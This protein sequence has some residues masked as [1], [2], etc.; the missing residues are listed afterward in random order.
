[1][2]KISNGTKTVLHTFKDID[3]QSPYSGV[4]RDG[5]GNL[6]GTTYQ[7]GEY[8]WG[9]VYKVSPTGQESV[10]FSFNVSDGAFPQAPLVEDSQGN[11][12]GFA[13]GGYAGLVFKLLP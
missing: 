13:S 6:Y 5:A 4:I 8:G 2:I 12:Y 1:V 10:L 11:L 9:T 7:G 3:G